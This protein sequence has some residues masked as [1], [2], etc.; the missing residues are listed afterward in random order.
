MNIKPLLQSI[1]PN[2]FLHDYLKTNGIEDV[3]RYLEP[4]GSCFEDW[5]LYPN[6]DEAVEVV[7]DGIENGKKFGLLVDQ[8]FDG[9][10]SSAII[11]QLLKKE[12]IVPTVFFHQNKSHGLNDIL[13]QILKAEIQVMIVPDAGTSDY[14]EVAQLKEHDCQVLVFDHHLPTHENPYAIIINPHLV[15]GANI[16]TSGTGVTNSFYK[17]FISSQ[18]KEYQCENDDLVA[19]S[20]VADVCDLGKSIENRAYINSGIKEIMNNL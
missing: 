10:A 5:Q 7:R 18:G 3:D 20:L 11:Y 6:I 1:N 13:D 12:N 4:D 8:D 17:A 15:E 16:Y 9:Y 19:F 2:T 14:L